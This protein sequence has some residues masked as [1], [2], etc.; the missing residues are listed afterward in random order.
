MQKGKETYPFGGYGLK[1][2]RESLPFRRVRA[3]ART[4]SSQEELVW[5]PKIASTKG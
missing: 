2:L 3:S 1:S 5:R 4:F